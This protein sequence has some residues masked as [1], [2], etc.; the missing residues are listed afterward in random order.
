MKMLA[1]ALYRF[2]EYALAAQA[3][4]VYLSHFPQDTDARLQLA[5]CYFSSTSFTRAQEQLQQVFEKA[6]EMP[7]VNYYMGRSSW[8][9]RIT[10]KPGV[11]LRPN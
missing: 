4:Q 10:R 7:Q 2:E 3:Y 1:E 8:R 9:R 6:P 5:I 11:I